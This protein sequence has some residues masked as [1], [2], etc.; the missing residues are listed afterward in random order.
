MAIRQISLNN[1][2]NLRPTTLTLHPRFN[3]IQG[4]NASGKTSFLEAV[5]F[6]CEGRSFKTHLSDTCIQHSKKDFL[7]FA[8]FQSYKVG[9]S[10]DTSGSKIRLDNETI[11]SLSTL[12][13][14]TPV[15]V[16]DADIFKLIT[17][18]PRLKREYL[19][20][21][22]FHVEHQYHEVWSKH[23]HILKQ[24]NALLKQKKDLSQLDQWDTSLV[25]YAEKIHQLRK[26]WVEEVENE[27]THHFD[28]FLGDLDIK[29]EYHPGWKIENGL[30]N[31]LLDKRSRD[32]RY[33][34]TSV[35]CHRDDL[36][37]T[38]AGLPAQQILSRGQIKRLSTCLYLAQIR[39]LSEKKAIQSIVLIDDLLS[40]LDPDAV[41]KIILILSKLDI[42][43][44]IT[45]INVPSSIT[46]LLEEY[47]L[48][49][50]EH[51][52]IKPVKR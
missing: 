52:M 26:R 46:T 39:I 42:Q 28:S 37:I 21:L 17:G 50:V 23:R 11:T 41:K 12:A 48:F 15:R 25:L 16:I 35:G 32:K 43:A 6:L 5:N 22:L 51:G 19:D 3:L 29:I 7:L 2:R 49:H 1:F 9:Y 10:R 31:E 4:F 36:I 8:R 14:N 44:F 47:K 20:W 18:S 38:S 30:K 45:T 40:E 24:R 27:I 34:F 33:G 13:R